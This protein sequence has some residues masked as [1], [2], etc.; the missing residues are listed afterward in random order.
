MD[1]HFVCS[2]DHIILRLFDTLP[3]FPFA[4]SEAKSVILSNK[5]GIYD[6]PHELPNDLRLRILGN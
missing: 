4:A 5:Y 2:H 1:A 3:N 6:L